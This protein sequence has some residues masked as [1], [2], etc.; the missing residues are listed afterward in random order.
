MGRAQ[1]GPGPFQLPIFSRALLP[2]PRLG[3]VDQPEFARSVNWLD[4]AGLPADGQGGGPARED[5]S[6]A[7]HLG[8]LVLLHLDRL[9]PPVPPMLRQIRGKAATPGLQSPHLRPRC[10]RAAAFGQAFDED[11]H[12]S[13]CDTGPLAKHAF[14]VVAT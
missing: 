9:L 8:G 4:S 3:P 13:E 2:L 5:G 6:A 10:F 11:A 1:C 7:S 12:N 14:E